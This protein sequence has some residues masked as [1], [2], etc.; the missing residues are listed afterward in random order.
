MLSLR[1]PAATGPLLLSAR[2]LHTS[3][4]QRV[5]H[6]FTPEGDSID[7]DWEHNRHPEPSQRSSEK[8]IFFIRHGQ[9]EANLARLTTPRE[10]VNT[11]ERF[12]DPYLTAE[13]EE[14]ARSLQTQVAKVG[15]IFAYCWLT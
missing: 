1:F 3:A 11:A 13:G 2:G 9:S 14:Q 6:K 4:L 12:R 15:A 5:W 7:H 8:H 10:E